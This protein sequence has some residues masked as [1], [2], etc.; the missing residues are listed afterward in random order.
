MKVL[1]NTSSIGPP[2]TGIGRY[3]LNLI[4]ALLQHPEISEIV[5]L[6]ATGLVSQST[7][8][9]LV[10]QWDCQDDHSA[11]AAQVKRNLRTQVAALPGARWLWRKLRHFQ[12]WYGSDQLKG[13]IYWEPNYLLVPFDGPSVA[14]IH[15]ISH[16]RM[17]EHHPAARITEMNNQMP[18]TL[19]QATRLIAVSAFTRDEIIACLNPAQQIDIVP[20]A[21]DP[22]FFAVQPDAREEARRRYDLPD[23]FILSVATLEPRKNLAR[24]VKAF[25]ALPESLRVRYPLVLA[26][27]RGW[28]TSSLE[29][30][31]RPLVAT[32]QIRVLGYV[33]QKHMP[34][35]YSNAT[36]LAYV[37][38]YE[39]FGMPIAEAMAVG[40]PVLTAS[41]SAMPEVA[42]GHALLVDPKST[43]AIQ[44]QLERLLTDTALRHHL[45]E[46][47][48]RHATTFDWSVSAKQLVCSLRAAEQEHHR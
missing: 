37:S 40:T 11:Q 21:V 38:L 25:A 30:S 16:L 26:G 13:F 8:Q 28:H 1:V 15:D 33:D 14:T 10:E 18:Q 27:S 3:T 35:L 2:L 12:A 32:G 42:A 39:G 4:K 34:A 45:S 31:I 22:S 29:S 9:R 43:P 47:A 23:D 46:S 6:T 24:L 41:T 36:L 20:P 48:R 5:G 19:A 7:L 44:Q 17:P